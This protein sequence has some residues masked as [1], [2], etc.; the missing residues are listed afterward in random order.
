MLRHR[1]RLDRRPSSKREQASSIL[2]DGIRKVFI[3]EISKI[4]LFRYPGRNDRLFFE[5]DVPYPFEGGE[6]HG[7]AVFT[8]DVPERCGL[9]YVKE[10]W[11]HVKCRVINPG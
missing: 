5:S 8:I 9:E 4:V 11:P 2:A 10:Y 3:V 1:G 6:V 7:K